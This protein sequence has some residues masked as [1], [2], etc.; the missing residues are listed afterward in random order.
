MKIAIPTVKNTLNSNVS[1]S[2]GRAEYFLI[3][4]T[5]T[6]ENLFVENTAKDSRG[7]AGIKAAQIVIDSK[8]EALLTPRLGEN[9][10]EVLKSS[11][12]K[13]Y[14]SI[15]GTAEENIEAFTGGKLSLLGEVHEGLHGRGLK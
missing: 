10:A 13:I 2:F 1:S 6:K 15:E 12:M 14:K 8:A 5:E 11:N 4:D 9:A 3:Y 7:G